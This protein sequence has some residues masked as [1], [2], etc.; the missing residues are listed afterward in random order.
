[1]YL[2]FS[3]R[4]ASSYAFNIIYEF[5]KIYELDKLF[6]WLISIYSI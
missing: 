6:K 2:H 5:M 3:E 4:S 1:M